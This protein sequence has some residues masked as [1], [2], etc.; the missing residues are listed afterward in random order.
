M[1]KKIF[2]SVL[3]LSMFV[4][5]SCSAVTVTPVAEKVSGKVT[6]VSEGKLTLENKITVEKKTTTTIYSVSIDKNTKIKKAGKNALISDISVGTNVTVSGTINKEKKKVTA[7]I[8]TIA[9]PK[10]VAK[11]IEAVKTVEPEKIVTKY[12]FGASVSDGLFKTFGS[13]FN[14]IGSLLSK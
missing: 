5:V 7:K 12:D 4:A 11:K 2:I 14:Y 6:A 8:I 13:V 9:V 3:L 10:P 1:N